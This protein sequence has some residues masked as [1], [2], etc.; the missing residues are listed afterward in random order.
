MDYSVH[1]LSVNTQ[2]VTLNGESDFELITR[3]RSGEQIAFEPLM[4]RYNQRLFR[5]SRSLCKNDADAMDILQDSYVI[6]YEKIAQFS[7]PD[8]F[9]GW[10]SRIVRN[11]ALMRIRRNKLIDIS[12]LQDHEP[13]ELNQKGPSAVLAQ[14]QLAKII[15]QAIDQLPDSYASVFVLRGVQQLSTAETAVSLDLDIDVVKTRYSRA[16]K[17]LRKQLEQH[18]QMAGLEVFEF[19]GERCDAVVDNV[20]LRIAGHSCDSKA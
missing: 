8:G 1:A 6:A 12:A 9:A 4:R 11:E 19:A 2:P 10:L 3:V 20:M 15:E 14:G 5:L 18:I 7:G 16:K 17:K 13:V